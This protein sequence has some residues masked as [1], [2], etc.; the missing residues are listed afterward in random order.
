[1]A[2]EG[3]QKVVFPDSESVFCDTNILQNYLNLEW[4]QDQTTE[5]L[6]NFTG[7]IV[8]SDSVEAE[9]WNVVDRRSDI[10][11]NLLSYLSD[12]ENPI[13]E[14]SISGR[15]YSNDKEHVRRIQQELIQMDKTEAAGR[16]R[17]FSRRYESKAEYV[18]EEMIAEIIF[19]APPFELSREIDKTIDN[20]H[21]SKIVSEAA[22]WTKEGGDGNLA[23]LDRKDILDF[24]DEINE[25]IKEKLGP[26]GCLKISEP[27]RGR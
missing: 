12:D 8:T 22:D 3:G 1:M 10:Y 17:R 15:N 9:F 25:I 21:D 6:E 24:T 20:S 26:E 11:P 23:A 13:G 18:I 14:Y 16:L 27:C 5:L 19:T 7:D 2:Q 4:E